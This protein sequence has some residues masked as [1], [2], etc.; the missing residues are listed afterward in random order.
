MGQSTGNDPPTDL[1][2][3]GSK[4]VLF[5]MLCYL[6]TPFMIFFDIWENSSRD[7]GELGLMRFHL[8]KDQ[9]F[10][11][12]RRLYDLQEMAEGGANRR[13]NPQYKCTVINEQTNKFLEAF[14][15]A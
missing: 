8:D 4:A 12:F 5:A 15:Q 1:G 9:V 3:G 14:Q 10:E 11:C 13:E 7:L 6:G 2:A